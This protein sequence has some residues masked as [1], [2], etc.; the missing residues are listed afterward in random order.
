MG[1][2]SK[3]ME[4]YFTSAGTAQ[5]E[6]LPCLPDTVEFWN[7]TKWATATSNLVRYATSFAE[8]TAGTAYAICADGN[9]ATD[10]NVTLTTGGFSFLTGDT[11]RLGPR[12]T[13]TGITAANPAVVTTSA[14]HN[15]TSGN[16]VQ[17]YGPTGMLQVGNVYPSYWSVTVLSTTT[18]SI[19]VDASG[20]AAAATGGYVKRIHNTDNFYPPLQQITGVTTGTTTVINL[21]SIQDFAVGQEVAFIIPPQWGMVELDS[22]VF[23]KTYGVP[24]QAYIL[25]MTAQ[26]ITVNLNSTAYTAFA[27]PTSAQAALGITPAQVVAIGDQNSGSTNSVLSFGALNIPGSFGTNSGYYLLIGIGNGTQI[28]HQTNDVCRWRAIFPDQLQ[29]S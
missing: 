23:Q 27:F 5:V 8:D 25:S 28:M 3:I 11:T 13:I 9:A 4:G 2:Y 10:K 22:N 15:L 29:T 17:I 12:L 26:S 1:Q 21:S 7:K 16:S 20:F 19:N 18:F 24:Q 14:V 6:L